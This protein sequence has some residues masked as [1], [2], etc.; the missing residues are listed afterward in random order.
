MRAQLT[1]RAVLAALAASA[2]RRIPDEPGALP[3]FPL[4]VASGDAGADTVVV[5]TRF[6]GTEALVLEVWPRADEAQV[7][8]FDVSPDATGIVART[9][10]GLSP[11]TWYG[12][13]FVGGEL[14]SEKGQFKTAP[15]PGALVPLSLMATSC[16]R[17]TQPLAPLKWAAENVE[18]DVWLCLGDAVYA[19]G[20]F[21][22][23]EY[24]AKWREGLARFPNRA[25]RAATSTIATWDDHEAVDNLSDLD[26]V[27]QV[28]N[29]RRVFFEHQPM[30]RDAPERIWRSRR[31]GDTAQIFVLDCRGERNH[32]THEYI[33]RAQL[34]WLK[35][36][37][38]ASPATFKLIM[39]SVPI[40]SFP[41]AL[42]GALADDRWEG[43]PEQRREVLEFMDSQPGVLWLSGDFHMGVAGRVALTGPG[44]KQLEFATGPAGSNL[45]NPALSYPAPPQFDF[46]SSI[47]NVTLLDL[48]PVTRRV[49]VR[50][51]S[52]EGQTL[53]E[54]DYD[55]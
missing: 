41:G 26:D 11:F 21:S 53:F 6:T 54:R 35:S 37:V 43:W 34:D 39:N 5:W 40:S 15:A 18:L 22:E 13:R 29:A 9:L 3:G 30:R 33:S 49:H 20:A 52:G 28:E 44:E 50:F 8:R 27:R 1:R 7:S 4:G 2:C 46:A 12:Y 48:D 36:A 51:V 24:R 31:W 42:Y 45:P 19:D 32:T 23:D 10:E 38:A 55:V 16:A 25:I 47:N 17:Q 14:S